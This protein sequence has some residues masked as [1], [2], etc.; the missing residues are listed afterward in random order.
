MAAI[1][2]LQTFMNYNCPFIHRARQRA[3]LRAVEALMNGGRLSLTSLGRSLSGDI[4]TKHKIKCIDR[5][6]GNRHLQA[7][8]PV[9]YRGLCHAVL[10][11]RQRPVILVDWSDC[12]PGRSWLMLKA[13][14]AID[15][16]ALTLYE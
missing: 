1:S 13:A 4:L 16:R 12:E 15:G 14:V 10:S 3:L 9:V 8:T 5:L 6:L 7:E 11:G 2:F